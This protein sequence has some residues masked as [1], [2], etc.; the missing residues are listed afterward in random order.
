ME[1]ER[2][3]RGV[4]DGIDLVVFDKDGTLIEFQAMWAGWVQTLAADLEAS[5]G[6]ALAGPL[7]EVLG[8]DPVTRTVRAHGL[9]AATPMSRIRDVVLGL[10]R[11]R[12]GDAWRADE[13]VAEAWRPPDPVTLAQPIGDLRRLLTELRR[14]GR[15]IAVA[16]SDDREPTVR[17]LDALGVDDLVDAMSCAD[18]GGPT[19]P[20]PEPVRRLC[21]SLGT[22][23]ARTAVVGDSVA[24]LAMAR[25]AGAARA[26]GVLS[27]V[28]DMATLEPLADV[29]L[30]SIQELLPT[31]GAA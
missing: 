9:L 6:T 2:F 30:G 12:T 13:A 27:G 3:V 14:S 10:V 19:K 5:T 21:E 20:S 31:G 24:D 22:V 15:R 28:A 16:T 26:I 17:T 25:A 29:V 7:F 23:P 1:P 4:L 8:V 18:D 11:E